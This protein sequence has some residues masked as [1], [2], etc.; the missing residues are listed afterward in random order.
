M[1]VFFKNNEDKMQDLELITIQIM[2]SIIRYKKVSSKQ[3]KYIKDLPEIYEKETGIK[4][5]LSDLLK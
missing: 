1:L 3:A 2:D 4:V 5:D